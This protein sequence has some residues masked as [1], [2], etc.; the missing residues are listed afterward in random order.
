MPLLLATDLT[1]SYAAL[2]VL[3][4]AALALEPGEK[5]ALV[6]RNGVGKTTLLRILAGLEAPDGGTRTLSG[7]ATAG[8]LP[9]DPTVDE[10]RTLWDEAAAPFAPLA[11]TER[12][13]ADLEARLA[14]PETPGDEARLSWGATTAVSSTPWRPAHWTWRR[15]GSKIIRA[16]TPSMSPNARRGGPASKR[17]SSDSRKRSRASRRTFAGTT[18]ARRAARR[19]R[20][21]SGSPRSSPWP[22]RGPIGPPRSGWRPRAATPRSFSGC[23]R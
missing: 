1:K 5:V 3:T 21:R 16:T 6:G 12:R 22:R 14:T 4:G 23:G 19:S 10:S 2:P 11:A 17:R 9:Q 18:P 20:G 8:Y 7:G 13:L 15:G